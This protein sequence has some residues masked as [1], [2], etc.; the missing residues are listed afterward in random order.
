MAD[1]S[2]MCWVCGVPAK[3]DFLV[4]LQVGT[5]PS[6][7]YLCDPD[8]ADLALVIEDWRDD[9]VAAANRKEQT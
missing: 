9:V 8:A 5:H 7:E 4:P 1:G 6:A 2:E 3:R